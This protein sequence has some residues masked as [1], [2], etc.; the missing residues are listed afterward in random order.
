MGIY[1]M[2]GNH[3][4]CLRWVLSRSCRR[5]ILGKSDGSFFK[6][7]VLKHIKE[8]CGKQKENWAKE[9]IR[10]PWPA[11]NCMQTCSKARI[12][13]LDFG[14]ILENFQVQ[15]FGFK[16]KETKAPRKEYKKKRQNKPRSASS[17]SPTSLCPHISKNHIRVYSQEG[18]CQNW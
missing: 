9:K 3:G 12:I 2:L 1:Q 6:N 11:P 14:K 16:D 5:E 4:S 13:L 10:A 15:S 7:R 18:S 8:K 17:F